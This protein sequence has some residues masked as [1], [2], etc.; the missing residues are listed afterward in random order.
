MEHSDAY[1]TTQQREIEIQPDYT[2][3]WIASESK[4]IYHLDVVLVPVLL[5]VYS[6]C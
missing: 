1:S 6:M 5:Y 2:I 4:L 3:N